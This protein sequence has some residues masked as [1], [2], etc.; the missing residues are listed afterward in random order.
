MDMILLHMKSAY[1]PGHGFTDTTNFL[2]DKCRKLANQNLFALFGTPDK[3]V[4]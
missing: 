4:S 2:F 3:M 1:G